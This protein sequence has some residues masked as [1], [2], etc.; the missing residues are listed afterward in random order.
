MLCG[1]WYEVVKVLRY[2]RRPVF[3]RGIDSVGFAVGV[4]R[5]VTLFSPYC[6]C[7]VITV[8]LPCQAPFQKVFCWGVD[9]VVSRF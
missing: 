9:V 3:I 8:F 7:Y 5:G 4:F 2:P 6:G 1:T